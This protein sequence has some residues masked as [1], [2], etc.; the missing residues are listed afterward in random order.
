MKNVDL[1]KV[2]NYKGFTMKHK[3]LSLIHSINKYKRQILRIHLNKMQFY[4]FGNWFN[5][6]FINPFENSAYYIS[7][8]RKLIEN[9]QIK[10][11]IIMPTY[12]R[13][14]CIENAINSLLKQTY[15]NYELIIIDDGSSDNTEELLKEKYY[16]Y[17]ENNKFEYIKHNHIGVSAARNFGLNIAKNDW[18][19]YLDTDNELKPNYLEEFAYAIYKNK[20]TCFY[21]QILRPKS[22]IIGR[23]FNYEKLRKKNYIDGGVFVHQKSL[24]DKY[25]NFDINLKRLVDWDLILRFTKKEKPFFIHKVLLTYNDNSDFSKITNTEN[26]EEATYIIRRK[27]ENAK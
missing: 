1:I 26:Y 9:S 22:G 13:A 6:K 3:I 2:Q 24:I 10:F 20:N 25:G 27:S 14:F 23:P 15:Q 7:K 16:Q 21:A 8:R 19:A 4:F 18:I 12:N 11:S 5:I 17:F